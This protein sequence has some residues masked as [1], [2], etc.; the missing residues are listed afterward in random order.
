MSQISK[1]INKV[2]TGIDCITVDVCSKN[3]YSG[4]AYPFCVQKREKF[5]KQIRCKDLENVRK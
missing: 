5:L 4:I 2:I 1:K 3:I